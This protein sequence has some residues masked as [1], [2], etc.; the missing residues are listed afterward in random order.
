MISHN[1]IVKISDILYKLDVENLQSSQRECNVETAS[2]QL[3][4]KV[5]TLKLWIDVVST[6]CACLETTCTLP[7]RIL[8]SLQRFSLREN[9]MAFFFYLFKKHLIEQTFCCIG[10]YD[11]SFGIESLQN[12]TNFLFLSKAPR[13]KKK[14][15]KKNRCTLDNAPL[16]IPTLRANVAKQHD[17]Q[18][19]TR[20][21]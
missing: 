18:T 6:L 8:H 12:L 19:Y 20:T 13:T 5:L 9:K 17:G 1:N 15:K 21:E 16:Q 4:F 11:K 7:Y 14:K 3:R 10:S 2:N